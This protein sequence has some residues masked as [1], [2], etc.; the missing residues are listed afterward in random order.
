MPC[1]LSLPQD[2]IVPNDCRRKVAPAGPGNVDTGIRGSNVAVPSC[3]FAWNLR[4]RSQCYGCERARAWQHHEPRILAFCVHSCAV[5]AL[6]TWRRVSGRP[7]GTVSKLLIAQRVFFTQSMLKMVGFI[8]FGTGTSCFSSLRFPVA[9]CRDSH[10][11][12]SRLRSLAAE[13]KIGELAYVLPCNHVI[14][15]LL[16][17][18]WLNPQPPFRVDGSCA[19]P[20]IE[21]KCRNLS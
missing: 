21:A 14:T 13:R 2:R 9:G 20:L 12:G 17:L 16:G 19:G 15:V 11:S 10:F 6:A 4:Q 3:R 8:G 7:R 5:A 1:S 18:H